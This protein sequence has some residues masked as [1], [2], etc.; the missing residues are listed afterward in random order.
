VV[1]V[2]VLVFFRPLDEAMR[3]SPEDEDF[4]EGAEAL[5]EDGLGGPCLDDDLETCDFR[6]G[7]FNSVEVDERN[8][9]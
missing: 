8:R 2:E 1:A 5:K 4:M 3:S 6:V 9:V 7:D